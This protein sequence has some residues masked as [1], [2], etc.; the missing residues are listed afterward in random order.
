MSPI[1]TKR[2]RVFVILF[3]FLPG[4]TP[5]SIRLAI[6][7]KKTYGGALR[8]YPVPLWRIAP[9]GDFF[10]MTLETHRAPNLIHRMM[11]RLILGVRFK[12]IPNPRPQ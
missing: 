5:G 8:V 3:G 4:N 11:Q 1:K 2:S 7:A 12:L 10:T 9:T 6:T